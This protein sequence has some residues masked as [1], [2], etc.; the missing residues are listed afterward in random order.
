MSNQVDITDFAYHPLMERAQ[1]ALMNQLKRDESEVAENLKIKA[2]ELKRKNQ[3]HQ[4]LGVQLYQLQQRI[5]KS[6]GLLETAFNNSQTLIDTRLEDEEILK[7]ETSSLNEFQAIVQNCKVQHL[8]YLNELSAQN[9]T[10]KKME[11]YITEIQEEINLAKRVA[12]KKEKSI[13]ENEVQKEFQDK[14]LDSLMSEINRLEV[15]YEKVNSEISLKESDIE[16]INGVLREVEEEINRIVSEKSQLMSKWKVTLSGIGRRDEAIIQA[17]E[18]LK[19]AQTA[20]LDDDAI[21]ATLRRDILKEQKQN[22][23]LVSLRDRLEHELTWVD[24]NLTKTLAEVEQCHEKY[25]LLTKSLNKTDEEEK[26]MESLAKQL[27][28]Q[29]ESTNLSLQLVIRERQK[30][31]EELQVVQSTQTNI[32]K[33]VQNLNKEKT[34]TLQVSHQKENESYA[35]ENEIATAK[36]NKLNLQVVVDQLREK[37]MAQ[38]NEL[39]EKENTII[40]YQNDIRQRNDEIEKKVYRVDRLNKKFD[41]MIEQAGGAENLD[42]LEN[43]VKRFQDSIEVTAKE[44]AELERSWLTKQT[45]M[46]GVLSEIEKLSSKNEEYKSRISLLTQQKFRLESDQ[47]GAKNDISVAKKQNVDLRKDIVKLNSLISE[48]ITQENELQNAN[49][50]LETVQYDELKAVDDE[51]KSLNENIA[52]LKSSKITVTE[53]IKET[54]RQILLWEKK[55]LLEKEMKVALDPLIGQEDIINMEKEIHRM[56]LRLEAIKKH[57]QT[58]STEMENAVLKRD[59]ISN[60]YSKSQKMSKTSQNGLTCSP[61]LTKAITTASNELNTWEQKVQDKL[62]EVA[63]Q[64]SRLLELSNYLTKLEM[65]SKELS[66]TIYQSQVRNREA[67]YLKQVLLESSKCVSLYVNQIKHF[68]SEDKLN[69]LIVTQKNNSANTIAQGVSNIIR[70]IQSANPHLRDILQRIN[71]MQNV[72][73]LSNL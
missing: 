68:E 71:D 48:G 14:Y 44:I 24:E 2:E 30:L 38:I 27:L 36:I 62:N 11:T 29:Y 55:L 6:Q 20:L 8:K 10:I 61:S 58:L 42:S 12:T 66:D 60:R 64:K 53:D 67:A 59:V 21:I 49:Y 5:A 7:N 22:E 70:D 54:D 26:K 73:F 39:K 13:R 37:N 18:T 4:F 52:E 56:I 65:Q 35:I 16:E 19:I 51:C 3:D 15:E 45:D 34:K 9:D 57:Q 28:L 41:R 33:A 63:D 47:S 40:K 46:V 23:T 50:T 1:N 69:E 32:N 17:S 31:E 43:S 25:T 72:S